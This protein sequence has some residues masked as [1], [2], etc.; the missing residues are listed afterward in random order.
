MIEVSE[1]ASIAPNV[2]AT[3]VAFQT[4]DG[5]RFLCKKT[6]FRRS[7]L[8]VYQLLDALDGCG[9]VGEGADAAAVSASAASLEVL[10]LPLPAIDSEALSAVYSFVAHHYDATPSSSP[11]PSPSSYVPP[12]FR[13]LEKPLRSDLSTLVD[14]WDWTFVSQTL[15]RGR[16]DGSNGTSLLFSVLNASSFLSIPPLRELCSAAIANMLRG[17]SDEAIMALFGVSS[18]TKEDEEDI[19]RDYPWLQEAEQ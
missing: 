3:H 10:E 18:F 2:A 1:T 9:V 17:K 15:L 19:C 16:P 8:L 14:P 5:K 13:E 11:S 7:S 12:T 6:I 4:S